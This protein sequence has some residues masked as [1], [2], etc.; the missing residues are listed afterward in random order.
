[1]R[2]RRASLRSL[3]IDETHSPPYLL[4]H[5]KNVALRT[6]YLRTAPRL[7]RRSPRLSDTDLTLTGFRLPHN[8][9]TTRSSLLSAVN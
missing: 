4:C 1:M 9:V 2:G 6:P 3:G 5:S 8:N 7:A